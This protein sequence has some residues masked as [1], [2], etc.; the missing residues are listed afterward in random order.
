MPHIEINRG[1]IPNLQVLLIMPYVVNW[2]SGKRP[3]SSYGDT[4]LGIKY[5]FLQES[6][7][8]PMVGIFPLVELP[9]GN[10]RHGLG[11]GHF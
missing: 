5:Q 2:A 9:T 3:V 1:A 6:L 4:E 10:S 8:R 7:N 11:S